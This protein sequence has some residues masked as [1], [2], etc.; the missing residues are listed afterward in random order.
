M[1]VDSHSPPSPGTNAA[2]IRPVVARHRGPAPAWLL[3]GG[4]ILGGVL[5][6]G[7]LDSQ[8]RGAT[9]PSTQIRTVDRVNLPAALP[10]LYLPAEPPPPPPLPSGSELVVVTPS[11][12]PVVAQAPRTPAPP[13]PA[14][15]NFPAPAFASPGPSP[16]PTQV[17]AQGGGTGAVLVIDTTAPPAGA[18]G[19]GAAAAGDQDP[20]RTTRLRRRAMTVP[21]GTLIPAVLETALDSTRPGHV[22]AI[23]SRDITGFDG[24]QILIPRGTRLF[25]DYQSDMAPGQNRALIQWTRLVRPDG[26]SIALASPSADMQGRAGVQGRVDSHF[27]E[28]FGAALL[29]STMNIG[30]ALITGS[31]AGDTPVVVASMATAAAPT[32]GSHGQAT[33]HVDAGARVGVLVARDLEFSSGETRR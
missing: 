20:V 3:F 5:L 24:S 21:Q 6:F 14:L 29:Q 28:R 9:A 15:P 27:L 12:Q 4:V 16:A 23:V 26:V 2:D 11:P 10:P 33:L 18:R 1:T 32:A 13:A 30:S 17:V 7:V 22:R 8:R 19:E 25:G 31:V